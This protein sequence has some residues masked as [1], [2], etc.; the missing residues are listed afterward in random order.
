MRLPIPHDLQ[1]LALTELLDLLSAHTL[2]YTKLIKE[3]GFSDES[4]KYKK[5]IASLQRAIESKNSKLTG[6]EQPGKIKAA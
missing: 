5:D 1:N 2:Y 4:E 6:F 3:Q